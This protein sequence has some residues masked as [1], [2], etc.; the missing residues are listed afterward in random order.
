ME[1]RHEG[2]PPV[3]PEFFSAHLE[4]AGTCM[5]PTYGGTRLKRSRLDRATA[6]IRLANYAL[7][8]R[9]A[10]A[11]FSGGQGSLFF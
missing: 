2:Q 9:Q 11:T 4:G 7:Q 1:I 6:A 5:A 10:R 3:Y 8:R